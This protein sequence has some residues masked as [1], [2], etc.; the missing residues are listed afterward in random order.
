MTW[1]GLVYLRHLRLV[2]IDD[3]DVRPV[4]GKAQGDAPLDPLPCAGDQD[5]L[6][7]DTHC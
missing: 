3:R 6:V 2:E 5:N 7:L 4:R 1:P